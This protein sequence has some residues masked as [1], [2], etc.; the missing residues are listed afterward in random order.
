MTPIEVRNDEAELARLRKEREEFGG[1][2]REGEQLAAADPQGYRRRIQR[3][4][5]LGYGYIALVIIGT[6]GMIAGLLAANI[7]GHIRMPAQLYIVL[8]LFLIAV[9]RSLPVK[10]PPP[11]DVS[12][13][14]TEAPGLYERVNEIADKLSAP[15]PDDIQIDARFNAAAGQYPRFGI[16]GVYRNVLILGLPYMVS[17]TPDE[18]A[19]VIGHELGHFSGKHGRLGV[20]VY[21][22]QKTWNRLYSN[23]R[24]S[25]RG[26]FAFRPFVEWFTPRF[27]AM[28]FAMR[29]QNEYEADAA[30]VEAT[31]LEVAARELYLMPARRALINEQFWT[32]FTRKLSLEGVP[33][34]GFLDPIIEA[35]RQPLDT[36]AGRRATAEALAEVTGDVDTHPSLKD[37]LR[38]VGGANEYKL[39]ALAGPSAAEALLGAAL[40]PVMRRLEDKLRKDNE[41]YWKEHYEEQSHQRKRREELV[42]TSEAKP[43]TLKE[44]IELAHF[45]AKDLNDSQ[46]ILAIYRALFDNFPDSDRAA[47]YYAACLLDVD[48]ESGVPILE[49]R[50]HGEASLREYAIQRLSAYHARH[51]NHGPLETLRAESEEINDRKRLARN[52]TH[53][54]LEDN[55]LPPDLTEEER[56]KLVEQLRKQP[57]LGRAYVFRKQ[58]A[59]TGAIQDYMFVLPRP[60]FE[61]KSELSQLV[62]TIV[63]DVRF[64]GRT[65]VYSLEPRKDWRKRLDKIPDSLIYDRKEKP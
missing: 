54:R 13:S 25:G 58:L 56:S 41:K 38:F 39:E 8:G 11:D 14:R 19:A 63:K 65:M 3:M 18:F 45:Q 9:V 37:R 46:E 55:L 6:I 52:T 29:R 35:A 40:P 36:D 4:I 60:K 21:R 28:T 62:K 42:Q 10:V 51:G 1:L 2:V 16:F 53:L 27:S 15:R 59:G 5:A 23:L 49:A 33:A 17:S 34:S 50:S 47:C 61:V 43:L 22:I 57:E 32:P 26:D 48:D 31:S 20:A 12:V 44:A 30:A 64:R 7:L 24:K